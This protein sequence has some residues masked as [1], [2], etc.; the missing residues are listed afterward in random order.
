[1]NYIFSKRQKSWTHCLNQPLLHE[2]KVIIHKSHDEQMEQ[3]IEIW[4]GFG[5]VGN[6]EKKWAYYEQL[7]RAF[8]SRF[9]GAKKSLNFF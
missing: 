4:A 9:S 5:P 8:F 7:L 3:K 2:G 1:M 6:T